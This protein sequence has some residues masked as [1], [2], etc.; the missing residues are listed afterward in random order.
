MRKFLALSFLTAAFVV[1]SFATTHY[2]AQTAGTFAGGIDCNGK[3]VV[4][5]ATIN[6]T[7]L[8]PGDVV[9]LCGTITVA[10]NTTGLQINQS[11]TSGNVITVKFDSGAVMTSPE[12]PADGTSGA[13]NIGSNSYITINGNGGTGGYTQGLVQATNNGDATATCIAGTGSGGKCG[14]HGDSNFLEMNGGNSN[15]IVEGVIVSDMYVAVGYATDGIGPNPGGGTCMYVNGNV[16]NLTV[17]GN[18]FHDMGWCVSLQYAGTSTGWT[19]TNNN[20]YNIDHGFALGS[21]AGGNTLENVI[22]SGNNVHDY[23]KW[24]TTNGYSA[25]GSWHH[26]GVHIWGYN[27]NGSDTIQNIAIYNNTFGGCIG[28]NVTAHIFMEQNAGGTHGNTVDI[29]NNTL[30]DTCDGYEPDGLLTTGVDSGYLIYNN[31]FISNTSASDVCVG[32]S[33]SPNIVYINNVS[34]GCVDGLSQGVAGLMY[35]AGGSVASGGLHNNIYAAGQGNCTGG[36]QCFRYASSSWFAAFSTW[37]SDTGQDASPSQYV[38]SALL[39]SNGSPQTGSAVINNGSNLTSLCS[40]QL[41]NLCFDITG[42][43]RPSSGA[44][45]A[46]AYAVSGGVVPT[47]PTITGTVSLTGTAKYNQ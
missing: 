34:S 44:W 5:L 24:D 19:F 32:T 17:T 16:T 3:T 46:G 11:G 22:I 21:P 23:Y 42:A 18:T 25:Q 37:Q 43:A 15:I 29:Y 1:P 14:L 33:S 12:W 45:T 26:D 2:V 27:D 47:P 8:S 20:I 30:I 38:S 31:T 28:R 39:N 9:E 10:T 4:T 13:I 35:L 40:G 41:I 36:G 7:T 6:S